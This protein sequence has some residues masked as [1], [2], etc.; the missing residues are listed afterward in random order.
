[1]YRTRLV[2]PASVMCRLSSG[3]Q[4]NRHPRTPRGSQHLSVAFA[5]PFSESLVH[6]RLGPHNGPSRP[7]HHRTP[8]T[9][10]Y[11]ISQADE[12]VM[13]DQEESGS[14]LEDVYCGP[15][16]ASLNNTVALGSSA[17]A[18]LHLNRNHWGSFH[19]SHNIDRQVITT[20]TPSKN[21]RRRSVA[22]STLDSTRC[23]DPN[24]LLPPMPPA[25][26]PIKDV[27]AFQRHLVEFDQM[28]RNI[29]VSLGR[30]SKL[31]SSVR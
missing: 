29:T 12:E 8:S 27:N 23:T 26:R 13:D 3:G 30:N 5:E 28:S 11:N 25:R 4:E 21:H 16:F 31:R 1:M 17:A 24:V 7:Y 10:H 19:A 6:S 22:A 9:A 15:R 2:T 14:I 18:K 20:I